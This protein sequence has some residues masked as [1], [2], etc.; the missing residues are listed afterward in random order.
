MWEV[1]LYKISKILVRIRI[2]RNISNRNVSPRCRQVS[3][4]IWDDGAIE[5]RVVSIGLSSD[6]ITTVRHEKDSLGSQGIPQM[7]G[8]T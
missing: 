8:A 4:M 5:F 6:F 2:I 1:Q 7:A 3:E